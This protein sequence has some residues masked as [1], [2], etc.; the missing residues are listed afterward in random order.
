M[1]TIR[2]AGPWLLPG[3]PRHPLPE[4]RR[5]LPAGAISDGH[6][7]FTDLVLLRRFH[8]PTGL[9][10]ASVVWLRL[11]VAAAGAVRVVL[12]GESLICSSRDV[13]VEGQE[14]WMF[15]LVGELGG[16]NEAEV[17]VEALSGLP[18][19]PPA[20]HAAAIVITDG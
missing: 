3:A 15:R 2:L 19:E 16:F 4:H 8:R 5:E 1:H 13:V 9:T 18:A 20:L 17:T 10:G 12:N 7:G 14:R 6:G 11:D